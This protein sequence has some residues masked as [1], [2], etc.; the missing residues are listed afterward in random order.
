MVFNSFT[1][2]QKCKCRDHQRLR[3][4]GNWESYDIKKKVTL[5]QH[6]TAQ[7]TLPDSK[8]GMRT[9]Q[10]KIRPKPDWRPEGKHPAPCLASEVRDGVTQDPNSVGN[11]THP[12]LQAAAHLACPLGWL[13]LNHAA[14]LADIS[15]ILGAR[16]QPRFYL[17]WSGETSELLSRNP[18][19][20]SPSFWILGKSFILVFSCL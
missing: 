6:I 15:S 11:L 17:P 14:I 12:S 1:W 4:S 5:L 13:L 10:G 3:D 2:V 8:R 18:T 19:L 20:P 9:N 7:S 16:L